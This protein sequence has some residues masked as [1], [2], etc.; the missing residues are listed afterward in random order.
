MAK[1]ACKSVQTLEARN[2][3]GSGTLCL[4]ALNKQN[5]I[6][7]AFNIGDSGFRLVRNGKISHKSEGKYLK[8]ES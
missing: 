6:M 7:H 5:S 8:N 4:L 3:D 1:L 2:I